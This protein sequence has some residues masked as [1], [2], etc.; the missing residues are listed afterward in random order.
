VTA[1]TVAACAVASCLPGGGA[2]LQY[3]RARVAEG[4]VWRFVTGQMVHWTARMA[5]ADLAVLL[6]F[7]LWLELAGRRRAVSSAL[8]LAAVLVAV[9]IQLLRP[10]L[11]LYRG[12]SGLASALFVLACLEAMRPPARLSSRI[13]AAGALL[14]FSAKVAWE[15]SGALP[16]FAGDLPEAVAAVPL[17]HLLG[18]LA[19][20]MAFRVPLI[21]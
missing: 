6:A 9:G 17:A 7:G 11:T 21:T 2:L 13:L 12:S 15:M 18:G 20:A 10:D 19:G 5:V 4:E 1:G 16:L 8:G 3:D 14:L